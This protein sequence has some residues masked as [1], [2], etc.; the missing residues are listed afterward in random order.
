MLVALTD[1]HEQVILNSSIPKTALKQLRQTTK[2]YCPQCKQQLQFKIGTFKIPHFA[3]NSNSLCDKYFSERE[4]ERHL[5]GKEQLYQFFH[6]QHIDVQLEPYLQN[7]KQRPDLLIKEGGHRFAVEFQCS[8]ISL[9]KKEQRNT[10]YERDFISPI[11]IPAQPVNKEFQ[12]GIMKISLPKQLQ[13]FILSSNQQQY[14]ML[15]DP[16]MRQ[17]IYLSNLMFLRGN[18]F[19]SKVQAL[20][21]TNQKFPFYLPKVITRKEFSQYVWLYHAYTHNYLKSRVLL[22]RK[23]VNDLFLRSIYELRLNI[24]TLPKF[25]GVPVQESDAI[26]L[27]TVEWQAALFYFLHIQQLQLSN[28]NN[29]AINYF[30]K[31]AS[32]PETKR[33]VCAV[34]NYCCILQSLSINHPHQPCL[35]ME[36]TNQLYSHFLAINYKY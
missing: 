32:L 20:P 35:E 26:S 28:M 14:I 12:E 36:L 23:G 11:W 1:R 22:S 4:T 27:Y 3:H 15:Y 17:F 7:L 13:Q 2:F 24:Q 16:T 18:Y 30:L 6:S 10:G 9:E 29:Q 21:I 19:I 8:P 33:T 34:K 31:W 25:I 5:L